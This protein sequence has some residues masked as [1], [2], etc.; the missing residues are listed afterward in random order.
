MQKLLSF[1]L[2]LCF[3]LLPLAGCA[4]ASDRKNVYVLYTSDVH[5]ALDEGLGYAAFAGYAEKLRSKFP[6]VTLLDCGDAVQGAPFA[7]VSRGEYPVRI[8][9]EIGY[10]F[11]L[12]GKHEFDY[13]IERL[14][15]LVEQSNA[16]YL[17][18]NLTYSGSGTNLLSAVKPYA[19][20]QYGD[21]TVGFVGVSA[22]DSIR[23][24]LSQELTGE[25]DYSFSAD[26]WAQFYA[27][28]QNSVDACRAEGADYVVALTH[29][30]ADE[31]SKPYRSRDLIAI[32]NGVDAVLDGNS[33]VAA[34]EYYDNKDGVPTLLSCA[35]TKL[36]SF[37][38]LTIT[39]DGKLSAELI[40]D[41]SFV[42]DSVRDLL[43]TVREEY[44]VKAATVLTDSAF[45]LEAED[46]SGVRIVGNRE[47]SLGNFCADAYRVVSGAD[48]ALVSAGSIRTGLKQGEI[49]Y[50]DL[51]AIQ[52]D[53]GTLCVV[54]ATGQ[55]ILDALEMAYREVELQSADPSDVKGDNSGFLHLSG[56]C[57][58]VETST[59]S[60]VV[61]DESG[62]FVAVEGVRRVWDVRVLQADGSSVPLRKE[63][64][65]TL[66]SDSDLICECAFGMTM[67]EKATLLFDSGMESHQVLIDF[68][69][70]CMGVK[71]DE[72]YRREEGRVRIFFT[73]LY[74]RKRAEYRAHADYAHEFQHPA[75]PKLPHKKDRL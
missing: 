5:C 24:V 71:L 42:S 1:V 21:V 29:M 37:G 17:A 22:P 51:I 52:P 7:T 34:C 11:A 66:A 75:L 47:C 3:F 19:I 70:Q 68:L 38:Q 64:T 53:A 45:A 49:C 31:T 33:D 61:T 36:N 16:E 73:R 27:G 12:L 39:P 8:M 63:Q 14:S 46:A 62:A 56:L 25:T 69:E 50:E 41:D 59:P 60:S 26:T 35:G 57:A 28:V 6:Y 40:R 32:T 48:V 18:C 13:G 2:V 72:G 67:F 9:N 74:R 58:T 23:P 4:W 20:R 44:Q 65:Y 54:E 15:E 30:G 43:N 10:D 55:Q